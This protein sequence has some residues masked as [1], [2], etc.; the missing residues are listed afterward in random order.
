MISNNLLIQLCKDE[1]CGVLAT[2]ISTDGLGPAQKGDSLFWAD[3][4]LVF[5]TV[6]GGANE[7]QV[8]QVC[9]ELRES[10]KVMEINTLLSGVLPS[11]GGTLQVRFDNLDLKRVTDIDFLKKQL[12]GAA[13]SRLILFGAGHVVQE[14]A[15]LADRN[16]FSCTIVDPRQE[17]MVADNFPSTVSL[18]RSSA[19]E[20]LAKD[21]VVVQDFII[22]AGPDHAT[23][24][25]VLEQVAETHAH[26]VGVMG[27][28]RKIGSFIEILQK[29]SLYQILEG[30][31][32]APVGIAISSKKPS[33][34][35]V[36]IVAELIAIRAN[37]KVLKNN[38]D[39]CLT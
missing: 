17:L 21:D 32:F 18:V 6:G 35:A 13:R 8:L 36:S 7:Q 19:D 31:L 26:Y 39:L 22:I 33:E 4:K 25:S 14:L 15:W 29:K 10:Q 2:V 11:C 23:D 24:L 28:K 27:S 9:A 38:K 5:G 34:V 37:S 16:G 3:G 30:R 1:V 12:K 20:W